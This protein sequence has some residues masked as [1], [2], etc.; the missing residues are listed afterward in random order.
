MKRIDS[1][2]WVA[3]ILVAGNAC[4]AGSEES[5][6]HL[7]EVGLELVAS[8]GP[9]PYST[10]LAFTTID[11]ARAC[12]FDSYEVQIVCGD[13]QW[14][15][16]AQF[17]REG[18]GPGELGRSGTL[19]AGS[20]GSLVF[21]DRR[22][23]R[24]SYFNGD[25]EFTGSHPVPALVAPMSDLS[26]EGELTFS[27]WPS[28]GRT[29]QQR[30]LQIDA[31]TGQ[32]RRQII[33][34]FDSQRAATD[35]AIMTGGVMA[36]D[37]RFLMRISAGADSH[38]AWYDPDGDLIDVLNLPRLTTLRPQTRERDHTEEVFRGV[39]SAEAMGRLLAGIEDRPPR[40]L[41]R[42]EAH[43]MLQVDLTGRAW[44][45]SNRASD[46]GS[47]FELFENASYI[48][49]LEVEGR[50]LAFHIRE[51]VLAALVEDMD[52]DT[53]GLY[54]RRIDWYRIASAGQGVPT[55]SPCW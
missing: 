50:V 39:L 44:I 48:G 31:T 38:V 26:P 7:P 43:R 11:T 32:V 17:G 14:V 12:V 10:S 27:A 19:V 2:Y 46:R 45:L 3:L 47:Y 28:P 49:S 15:L 54:P 37:G 24:A 8:A 4:E 53:A 41:P 34:E 30:L 35:T 21:I 40:M 33:L 36:P 52:P 5:A 18:A 23:Q 9:V 51:S 20:A 29:A 55:N 22:N 42:L 1:R 13:R 6:C 16:P 25:F